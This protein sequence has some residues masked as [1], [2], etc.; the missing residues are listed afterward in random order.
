MLNITN[1]FLNPDIIIMSKLLILSLN[2]DGK[3]SAE[4][5]MVWVIFLKKTAVWRRRI[6]LRMQ[7]KIERMPGLAGKSAL[8]C[9]ACRRVICSAS[10]F[11]AACCAVCVCFFHCP[12][13][14]SA[15]LPGR[16]KAA[17]S[18]RHPDGRIFA[19]FD[20]NPCGWILFS[21]VK[22]NCMGGKNRK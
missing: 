18:Q 8:C 22:G 13:F 6:T 5:R 14:I 2:G 3:T 12:N 17:D 1:R 19:A 11:A 16:E 7:R 9:R 4:R 15:A 10:I 20:R 21:A